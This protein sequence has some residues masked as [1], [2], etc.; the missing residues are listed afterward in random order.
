MKILLKSLMWLNCA[1]FALVTHA[2]IASKLQHIT[3]SSKLVGGPVDVQIYLP[4]D[5]DVNRKE[6]YSTLYTT[7]GESRFDVLKA[8]VDWLSHTSFSPIPQLVIVRVPKLSFAGADKLS[9]QAYFALLARVLASE[10]EPTLIRQFNLSPFK[11]IEGYSSRAAIALNLL[12]EM[13]GYFQGAILSAPIWSHLPKLLKE[14][15]SDSITKGKLT[16]NLYISLGSFDENR[17]FFAALA[18]SKRHQHLMLEDL[19]QYHYHVGAQLALRH[20]LQHIL[21]AIKLQDYAQ[22][23]KSG[24]NGLR[25]YHQKLEQRYGYSIDINANQLALGQYLFAQGNTILGKNA[26][27][28]L[29]TTMPNSVIYNLRYGQTLLNAGDTTQATLQLKRALLLATEQKNEE[30]KQYIEQVLSR[31]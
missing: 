29:L 18:V 13:P 10:V 2:Q 6:P 26:F 15:I 8:E 24:L 17:P 20:G 27:D 12:G 4:F 28:E 7:A 19:S 1:L 23:D 21:G 25:E 30:A 14:D 11:V 3:V 9:D 22:F 16:N 5:F 31:L